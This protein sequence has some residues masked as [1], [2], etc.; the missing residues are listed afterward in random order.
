MLTYLV[1][2]AIRYIK[3][4]KM[5]QTRYYSITKSILFDDKFIIN[6]HF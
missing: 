3:Y 4:E 1:F 5:G 6:D 2:A